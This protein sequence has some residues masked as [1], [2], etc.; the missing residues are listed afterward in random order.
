MSTFMQVMEGKRGKVS[1]EGVRVARSGKL[2]YSL[3]GKVVSARR[4][5]AVGLCTRQ[6]R[7]DAWM[8]WQR[9][10]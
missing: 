6:R 9:G 4:K 2:F 7:L 5:Y 1:A 8:R 10:E 3:D